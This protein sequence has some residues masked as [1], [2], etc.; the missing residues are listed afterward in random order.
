MPDPTDTRAK[1]KI[2]VQASLASYPKLDRKLARR[3]DA[4]GLVALAKALRRLAIGEATRPTP[5]S[6]RR[7]R[8]QRDREGGWRWPPLTPP[9]SGSAARSR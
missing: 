6:P 4:V 2:D 9:P 1:V 5:R 8:H 7:L 3:A